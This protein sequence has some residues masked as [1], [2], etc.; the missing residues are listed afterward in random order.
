MVVLSSSNIFD[1]YNKSP[2]I[3]HGGCLPKGALQACA[4]LGKEKGA[5]EAMKMHY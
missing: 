2:Y 1:S 4:E 3:V 5:E